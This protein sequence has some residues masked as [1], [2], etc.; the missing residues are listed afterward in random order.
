MARSFSSVKSMDN[1]DPNLRDLVETMKFE[2]GVKYKVRMI[3]PPFTYR[4]KWFDLK[5]KETGKPR[6]KNGRPVS[7][8]KR[9]ID[10]DGTT[11]TYTSDE[12]PYRA[13]DGGRESTEL[14]INV[15]DRKA[16]ADKPRKPKPLTEKESQRVTHLGYKSRWKES[17]NGGGWTPVR[18]LSMSASL[19]KAIDGAIESAEADNI[20]ISSDTKGYDLIIINRP[21]AKDPSQ[22]W[23]VTVGSK[24]TPI[25]DEE[26]KY[27]LWKLDA[28]PKQK[29]AAAKKDL[30]GLKKVIYV[31][32]GKSADKSSKSDKTSSKEK[33][34]S[35]DIDSMPKKKK[36]S[37]LKDKKSSKS[38]VASKKKRRFL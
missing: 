4:W 28:L 8:P 6:T 18:V 13:F 22:R 14:V 25:T 26:K 20:D 11:D 10:W 21:T 1:R 33:R 2:D 12:C 15:I 35:D 31:G 5:D 9:I 29:P 36:K 19:K 27:A 17:K 32:D 38:S 16:Q 34:R 37:G 7:L 23:S 3:G 24:K 30:E